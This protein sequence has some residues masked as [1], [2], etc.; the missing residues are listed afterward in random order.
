MW[1]DRDTDGNCGETETSMRI[2]EKETLVET[3]ETRA[4]FTG[5][6]WESGREGPHRLWKTN[7]HHWRDGDLE[8]VTPLT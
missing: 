1:R 3:A 2:V 8:I 7:R 4:C 6:P 5:I